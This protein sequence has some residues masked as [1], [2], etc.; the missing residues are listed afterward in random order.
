MGAETVDRGGRPAA[1]SPHALAAAAQRLFVD[2][3]FEETSVE[4]IA[5]AVG[6]SRRTFFRYFSTKADVLWVESDAEFDRLTAYLS[7]DDHTRPP[8]DVVEDAIVSALDFGPGDEE[9]ALHRTQLV[10][11]VPTVQSHASALYRQWRDAVA[12]YVRARGVWND[13]ELFVIAFAHA[14][15]AAIMTG[16]EYWV[17]HPEAGLSRSLRRSIELLVPIGPPGTL[18]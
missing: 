4:D 16:H 17:S 2:K 10:L 5:V 8:R 15:T 6:V 13:D 14:T 11:T 9:W 18:G 12:D 3:G 1:T 7:A